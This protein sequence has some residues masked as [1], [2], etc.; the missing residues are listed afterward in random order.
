MELRQLRSFIAVAEDGNISR[1]AQRLHLTQSALSR[2]I[3]ALEE[4][5]GVLLLD[6]G[7]HSIKLT[8]EGEVLLKEGRLVVERADIAIGKV[9]AAGRAIT[10]RVGY[11]PSLTVGMLPVA[12]E[13]FTQ[14][15]PRVRVE[16]QDLSSVEMQTGLDQG[17]L[18]IIVSVLPLKPDP[19]Q[20]WVLLHQEA[21][22]LA[23][24]RNHPLRGKKAVTAR[25]LDGQRMVLFCQRDYPEYW[26][27][28]TAWF[29]EQ[30]INAKVAGEYD[31]ANSLVSAVEAG[32]GAALVVERMACS[33]PQRLVLKPL[34][35]APAPVVIAAGLART[36][37]DDPI[38]QVFVE[39]LKRAAG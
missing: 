22:R 8:Q 14:R 37:Q 24:N 13:A 35:P 33:F 19:A 6:R 28:V 32:L 20:H 34:Q 31:G 1:A 3:K 27:R 16:L 21:W 9:Q 39:E 17:Q 18:D 7:A 15:H 5:L 10:L 12:I 36:K 23:I 29:K 30:G 2:Q 11:A 25:D 38:L 4:D 26:Q